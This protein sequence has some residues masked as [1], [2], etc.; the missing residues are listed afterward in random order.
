[1]QYIQ[2]KYPERR[3]VLM[4]DVEVG[5]TQDRDGG[6]CVLEIPEGSHTIRLGGLH[7]FLPL[8][9]DVDLSQTSRD[10]PQRLEFMPATDRIPA[11]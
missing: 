6:E 2:V 5:F 9:Q 1:M 8:A 11:P 10:N 7:D 3:Q 4:D